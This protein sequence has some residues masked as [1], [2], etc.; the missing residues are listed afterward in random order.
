MS[1]EDTLAIAAA[2]EAIDEGARA[3]SLYRAV[4]DE[5]LG[6]DM[7]VASALDAQGQWNRASAFIGETW[8][9]YT[10]SARAQDADLALAGRLIERGLGEDSFPGSSAKVRQELVVTGLAR[11]KRIVSVSPTDAA[12]DAGLALISALVELENWD[13]AALRAE[14]FSRAFGDHSTFDAFRYTEAVARWNKGEDEAAMTLLTSIAEASYPVPGGR[15]RPSAN[16]D[17]ALY[18]LAQIHHARRDP[19]KATEF[20]ERVDELFE[21]AATALVELRAERLDLAEEIIRVRPGEAAAIE[22]R[23]KGLEAVEVLVYPVDLMTLALRERDLSRVTAV[24]LAGVT[25]LVTETVALRACHV[26]ARWKDVRRSS[27]PSPVPTSPCCAAEACTA[28]RF[29]W[30]R[31]SRWTSPSMHKGACAHTS[32]GWRT[33]HSLGVRT[34]A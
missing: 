32:C 8:A 1:F 31:T 3:L 23:H 28:L 2:Y 15:S 29:S 26:V 27:S 30:P 25:P 17:L 11:L 22:F 18:I 6:E 7:R 21:D 10:D 34:C 12:A 5:T 33:G 4:I 14:L 20:Y 13:E 24:D 19:A 9:R 16:R